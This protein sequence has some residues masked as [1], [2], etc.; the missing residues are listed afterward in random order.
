M[1]VVA[2]LSILSSIALPAYTGL[3]QKGARGDA[4]AVLN[5]V[6]LQQERHRMS[7]VAYAVT[8]SSL[9]ID[10]STPNGRYN[11]AISS[12]NSGSFVATATPTGPQTSDSCG[13]FAITQNGPDTSGSYANDE[14]WRR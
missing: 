9:S 13:T 6:R 14:C 12:A 2:L 3:V 5:D 11:I 8:L 1:I 10:P 7:E 4:M